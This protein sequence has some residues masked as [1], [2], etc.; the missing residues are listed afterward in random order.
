MRLINITPVRKKRILEMIKFLFPEYQSASIK[1]HNTTLILRKK[2][3]LF[4]GKREYLPITDIMLYEL[5]KRLD[6][7]LKEHGIGDRVSYNL[8]NMLE[9]II[10]CKS[11]DNYFD[12]TDYI[13]A[14][15][16]KLKSVETVE[17]VNET[18]SPKVIILPL[19]LRN[20]SLIKINIRE[21]F[22]V[23]KISIFESIRQFIVK[24]FKSKRQRLQLAM[25]IYN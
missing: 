6:A 19:Y 9:F 14:K 10:K 23:Q 7:K 20:L 2:G 13:Y 5:P 18:I 1:N 11:F 17:I 4:F 3:F 15:F 8:S 25:T 12:I 16:V 22:Y 24:S 21:Y